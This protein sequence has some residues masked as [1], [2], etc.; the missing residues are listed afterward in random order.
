MC[1]AQRRF[2]LVLVWHAA[3]VQHVVTSAPAHARQPIFEWPAASKRKEKGGRGLRR[4]AHLISTSPRLPEKV[5]STHSSVLA[6][7]KFMYRSTDARYPA[8]GGAGDGSTRAAEVGGS[9]DAAQ[10]CGAPLYSIPHFSFTMH[11]FPVSSWRNGFGLT[12]TFCAQRAG[13]ESQARD[14]DMSAPNEAPRG[15]RERKS[16]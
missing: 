14:Q 7:C 11:G 8:R 1:S 13:L 4:D 15:E 9:H 16:A 6:S 12:G 10:I 2:N 5:P 3:D